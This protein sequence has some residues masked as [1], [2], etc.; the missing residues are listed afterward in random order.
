MEKPISPV[1]AI[2]PTVQMNPGNFEYI[3]IIT[4][5][6]NQCDVIYIQIA[7]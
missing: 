4:E 6:N 1:G 7:L 2:I 3:Y 5:K